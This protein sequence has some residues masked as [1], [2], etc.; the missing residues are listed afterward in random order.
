M[1]APMEVLAQPIITVAMGVIVEIHLPTPGVVT[2]L[3]TPTVLVIATDQHL[4]QTTTTDIGM[5]KAVDTVD[6][7]VME[8]MARLPIPLVIHRE[9]V[10]VI[11]MVVQRRTGAGVEGGDPVPSWAL[12]IDLYWLGVS[13]SQRSH[14]IYKCTDINNIKGNKRQRLGRCYSD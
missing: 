7:V 4:V 2:L 13:N 3:Q 6:T 1:T 14:S 5:E 11:I 12:Y 8:V 10:M 9:V